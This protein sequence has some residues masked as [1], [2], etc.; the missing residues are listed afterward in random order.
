[1]AISAA[2]MQIARREFLRNLGHDR[3]QRSQQRRTLAHRALHRRL[4]FHRRFSATRHAVAQYLPQRRRLVRAASS[5]VERC[6]NAAH[7]RRAAQLPGARKTRPFDYPAVPGEAATREI[8]RIRDALTRPVTIGDTF[9]R[10]VLTLSPQTPLKTALELVVKRGVSRFPIYDGARF[11]GLLTENGIARHV[12]GTVSEGKS[13]DPAI[14]IQSVLP[15]ETKRRN[16]RFADP[17]TSVAQVAF[18][19]H[20]DTFLEAVLV[21]AEK[22]PP[23]GIVTRGDVVGWVE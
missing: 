17:L 3:A 19:F 8:E 14:L 22:E 12:A 20:D 7:F 11:V 18:W 13:F 6:R 16:Y 2:R 5:L 9:A 1:M 15:R 4:Q 21:G 23:R 10:E